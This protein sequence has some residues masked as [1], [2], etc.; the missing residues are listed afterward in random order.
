DD[1]F[2]LGGDSIVAIQIV[3]K[4]RAEGLRI[5]P[6]QIFAEPTPRRLAALAEPLETAVKG[7]SEVTAPLPLT[8]IQ[9]WFCELEVP[10]R[11]RWCLTALFEAPAGTT[12]ELLGEALASL[13]EHH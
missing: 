9:T 8:P 3:G 1:F 5:T 7:Q 6:A 4:A 10:Q 13:V 11:N 12:G 2:A